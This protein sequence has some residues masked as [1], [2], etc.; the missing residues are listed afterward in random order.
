M[1]YQYDENIKP[2]SPLGL[3]REA[4][5]ILELARLLSYAPN[6]IRQARGKKEPV[7]VIPGFGTSDNMTAVLRLYLKF[8]NYT[9]IGWGLGRNHG[10]VPKLLDLLSKKFF[11]GGT[12]PAGPLH[13]VGWS[14]G[15]Y[16]ARELAREYPEQVRQ[17]IT[18]GSP[19]IGGPK[20]TVTAGW[21]KKMGYDLDEIEQTVADRYKKMLSVP[22]TAV[23]SKKDR[24]V[25][26]QACIDLRS[27]NVEHI[28]VKTTHTGFG[29]SPD[30]FQ[31]IAARLAQN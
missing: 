31:I 12:A 16:L 6:L 9:P 21:Y 18:F 13:L 15:G 1:Q 11:P 29:F 14:L 28:E 17:V 4:F 2:P 5:G 30:V 26:W 8:L 25:A 24:I 10:K 7:L 20:Y 19:V 3:V 22:V 27:P 23:Y